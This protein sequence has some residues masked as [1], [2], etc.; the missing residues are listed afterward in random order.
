MSKYGSYAKLTYTDTDSFTYD[1][2]TPDLYK[3]IA[4]NLDAY[5]TSDYPVDH[6]LKDKCQGPRQDEGR[7]LKFGTARICLTTSQNVQYPPSQW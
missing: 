6:P 7:M 5:D 3:D 1:I 2:Q 4:D